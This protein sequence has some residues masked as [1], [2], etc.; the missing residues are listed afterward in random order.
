MS[1]VISSYVTFI[2]DNDKDDEFVTIEPGSQVWTYE[3]RGNVHNGT[4][5]FVGNRRKR[6][7]AVYEF[8]AAP[9][10]LMRECFEMMGYEIVVTSMFEEPELKTN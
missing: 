4:Y 7:I 3:S 5:R 9:I 1:K 6:K 10:E 8:V 2:T